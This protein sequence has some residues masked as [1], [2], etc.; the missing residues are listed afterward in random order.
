MHYFHRNKSGFTLIELL[1]VVAIIAILAAIAVPNFL[2]AQTRS[3]ISRCMADLR[4]CVL[5]MEAYKV[6][7]NCVVWEG[8]GGGTMDFLRWFNYQANREV[9]IGWRL[10]TPIA[11]MTSVPL[12]FFNTN[13]NKMLNA[14]NAFYPATWASFYLRG[15]TKTGRE[16]P[17]VNFIWMPDGAPEG[18][19]SMSCTYTYMLQSAGPDLR[20]WSPGQY[21]DY[22]YYDPT[23]GTASQGD[24]FYID[25][26]GYRPMR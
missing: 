12:D 21:P 23:N 4:T 3:K 6:D 17:N 19:Y 24:V 11:Y 5:A 2:E 7:N 16:A 25:T 13:A 26:M 14:H 8:G 10:T 15:A 1:I 20:Y 9:G 18:H 22:R